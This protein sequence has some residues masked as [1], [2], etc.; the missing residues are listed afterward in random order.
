MT[1]MIIIIEMIRTNLFIENKMEVVGEVEEEGE[2]AMVVGE[3]VKEEEGDEG[4]GRR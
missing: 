1:K 3:G 4:R 2:I